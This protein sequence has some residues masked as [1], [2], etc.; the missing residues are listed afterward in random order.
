MLVYTPVP[1]YT[2][3]IPGFDVLNEFNNVI[4]QFNANLA[5]VANP[6]ST[7]QATPFAASR[8]YGLP[9][10]ATPGTLLTTASTIYAYPVYIPGNAA[11]KTIS[12]YS[13]TGQ[14][15]GAAHVGLYTDVNGAPG[16]LVTGSDSGALAATASTTAITATYAT[17]LNLAPGWYWAASTFSAS[18]TMPTVGAVAASYTPALNANVGSASLSNFYATSA[19]ETSGVTATFTYAALP[20]AFPSAGFALNTALAIPLIALG[21]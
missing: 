20:A 1:V 3:P 6:E 15:G 17:A 8:F 12:F 21:T 10:G 18:S 16:V 5:A 13:G 7:G 11:I 19:E 9:P 2:T 14:T 4:N